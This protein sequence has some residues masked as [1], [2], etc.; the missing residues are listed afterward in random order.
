MSNY[1][2]PKFRLRIVW[3]QTRNDPAGPP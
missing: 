1:T 3:G 2:Q